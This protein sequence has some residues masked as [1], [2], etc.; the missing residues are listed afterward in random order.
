ME[1]R[2][3]FWLRKERRNLSI[4]WIMLWPKAVKGEPAITVGEEAISGKNSQEAARV[5]E[6]LVEARKHAITEEER[7]ISEGNALLVP[8]SIRPLVGEAD[9]PLW[10]AWEKG[11]VVQCQHIGNSTALTIRTQQVLRATQVVSGL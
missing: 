6:P 3:H 4:C 11:R 8:S 1:D 9:T 10:E 2:F 7:V 5:V